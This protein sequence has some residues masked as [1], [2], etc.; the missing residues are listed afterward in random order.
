MSEKPTN[1]FLAQNFTHTL[2][3]SQNATRVKKTNKIKKK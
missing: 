1:G 2:R 3:N